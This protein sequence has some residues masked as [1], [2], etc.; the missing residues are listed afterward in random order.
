MQNL[1]LFEFL[2]KNKPKKLINITDLKPINNLKI[3]FREIRDY[4][5]GNVT[6][7]TRDEAIAQNIMRLLFCKIYDE[8]NSKSTTEFSNRPDEYNKIFKSR[9]DNLFEKVKTT[10]PDIFEKNEKIEIKADDLS[11]IVSKLEDYSVLNADRDVIGDAFEE[12]IG[13]SFRG[14]EGQFFTPRNVV[15]MM[16]DVLQPDGGERIIDP[17]CGSGGFLSYTIR[18]LL[19]N[20]K[21]NFYVTG[22]DKDPSLAQIAK[23]YLSLIVNET[24]FGVSPNFHIY[25]ENSLENPLKWNKKTQANIKLGSFD[26]VLTNPPF[27]AK[28]PVV[29]QELLE[30]Y[31]LGYKWENGDKRAISNK[32]LDKQSPQILFIERCLQLLREGGRLAIVLPDGIFGNPSDKYIWEYISGVASVIGVVSLSQETFQPSTHTKTSILFLKKTT[33]RPKSIF[34]AIANNVGH[35]KNGNPS[36]KIDKHGNM[37]LDKHG[38]KIINDDLP[39]IAENFNAHN[40]NIQKVNEDHLGFMVAYE[41]LN[42]HIF[43]PE[44]Y[45]PEIGRELKSLKDKGKHRLISVEELIDKG[46]LQIKR[47]NEIGSQFYGSGEIPFVRTSDIVNWEIKFDPIKAVSE[48]IY[49][50]YKELQDIREKDILFVNDGT[51]LIGRT[52]MITRL[53]LRIIIQSHLRRIRILDPK[54]IDPYYL[55]Y[56]LNSKLVRKQIDSRIFVQATI[57]TIGN[58]LNEV[59]LPICNDK[60]EVKKII[61]EVKNIIEEKAKL[62]EKTVKIVEGSI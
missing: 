34:M 13:T 42:D 44:Y 38:N 27:G 57:S 61:D 14:G 32:A 18:Y 35:N 51:F 20:N 4:F 48:E 31:N 52:A 12:L 40:N 23:I 43:I 9:I 25:C 54:I 28:I 62:R 37:I 10:Y 24:E 15:Q 22:I 60:N 19:S 3:I 8:R 59:I 29:G 11:F 1:N 47:G 55:F 41:D 7:I 36:Y 33:A 26:V 56:L 50:Q 6:G 39:L 21:R 5:A 2:E 16:I 45:N 58:R 17:A 49:N 30:Q 53:D 46:I